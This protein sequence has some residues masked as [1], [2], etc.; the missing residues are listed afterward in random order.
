MKK[1]KIQK[2]KELCEKFCADLKEKEIELRKYCH[3]KKCTADIND[4]PQDCC[5]KKLGL[6][7]GIAWL[8]ADRLNSDYYTFDLLS[9]DI[10]KSTQYYKKE[11]ER[12]KDRYYNKT[13]IAVCA[14]GLHDEKFPKLH[15]MITEIDN[16]YSKITEDVSYV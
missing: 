10:K 14:L 4:C 12:I 13:D 6:D 16:L 3:Y 15:T 1:T 5:P 11:I 8:T 7:T 9:L 2:I